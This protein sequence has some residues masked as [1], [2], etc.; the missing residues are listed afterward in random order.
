MPRRL[1]HLFGIVMIKLLLT[2]SGVKNKTIYDAL[3]GLLGKPVEECSALYS[4]GGLRPSSGQPTRGV[5]VCE[6]PRGTVSDDRARLEV[7]RRA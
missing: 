6:R 2:D 5:S 1:L 7:R 3:V 4:N